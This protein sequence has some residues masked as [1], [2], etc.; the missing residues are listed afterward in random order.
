MKMLV[1]ACVLML[2][3]AGCTQPAQE[4]KVEDKK[5]VEA[6]KE[7]PKPDFWISSPLP[8]QELDMGDVQVSLETKD[9]NVVDPSETNVAGE[10]HFHLF[11]DNGN[12][13]PCASKTCTVP[14]VG[15]GEHVIK[16]MIQQNDH[17][18]YAAEPKSVKIK[19]TTPPSFEIVSPKADEAV[20]AG[21]LMVQMSSQYFTVVAPSESNVANQG[22]FH[23]FLDGGNYIPCASDTCEV[24]GVLP[25]KHTVKV[26][27]QQNDHSD[28]TDV[29]A[30]EVT[31]IATATTAG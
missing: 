2:F 26:M 20:K 29:G 27:M 8:G 18:D 12:Y 3:L 19:V 4:T 16:V 23:L 13:I 1:F 30:K 9:L 28:Y 21:T 5:P 22:H 7:K 31:F 10:G 6:M 17:S 11:L 24:T 14:A 25:G 15:P